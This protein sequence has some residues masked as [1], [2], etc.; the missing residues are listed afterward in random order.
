MKPRIKSL[1][2]YSFLAYGMI[3][4]LS[5]CNCRDK[6]DQ[7]IYPPDTFNLISNSSFE[8]DGSESFI[9]WD[10]FH[11]SPVTLSDVPPG[12]GY[13][14]LFMLGGWVPAVYYIETSFPSP[15]GSNEYRLSYYGKEWG[16]VEL[17]LKKP[18]TLIFCKGL[19]THDTNWTCYSV[20]D[21]LNTYSGDTLVVRVI[22]QGSE[23]PRECHFDL[24]KLEIIY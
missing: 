15:I 23:F 16:S 13:Y 2:L 9:G 12:G 10:I 22:A 1:I 17:F 24:C 21:T 6:N 19:F 8:F 14:S 20:L 11:A 5:N 7:I 18:D 3:S 4:M